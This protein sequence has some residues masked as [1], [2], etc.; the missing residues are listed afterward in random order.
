MKPSDIAFPPFQG[1]TVQVSVINGAKC[2]MRADVLL[3]PPPIDQKYLHLTGYSFL[4]VSPNRS[5]RV[6]YD[7]AFMADLEHRVPP[8]VQ[9]LVAPENGIMSI[10]EFHHVPDVLQSH[11]VDLASINAIIWSH[12]HLDHT[13]DPSV[14]PPTTDLIV[15]PGC[16]TTGYPSNSA[17]SVLDSAFKGRHVHQVD[18][19]VS[20]IMIGGF[21]ALDYFND[22]SLYLLHTPGHT[23]HHVSA[24]CRTAADT[25]LLLAG[26]VCHSVSQLRPNLYRQ[27][28]GML[29]ARMLGR[30][31]PPEDYN[32]N[33]LADHTSSI[34]GLA[35]GMQEDLEQAQETLERLSIFD[36][37]DDVMVIL[38]HDSSL[39]EILEFFPHTLNDW[40][41][42]GWADQSR[43][44]FLKE[45]GA[46]GF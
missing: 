14:F 25:W 27:H 44:L 43:W 1:H 4:I 34:H 11:G 16:D 31:L 36:G 29:P 38:A 18:F 41:V 28:P 12:A 5:Q 23:A 32:C 22:G 33:R 37:R 13:G 42:K 2:H 39:L 3:H 30:T 9:P 15:G 20:S 40:K 35:P 7:L 8:A 10:D 46:A 26:D 19:S 21:P 45:L 6:I 17:A 24:L